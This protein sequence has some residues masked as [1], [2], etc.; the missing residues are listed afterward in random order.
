MLPKNSTQIFRQSL[1]AGTFALISIGMA[2]SVLAQIL[3]MPSNSAANPELEAVKL[4]METL[5]SRSDVRNIKLKKD[6]DKQITAVCYEQKNTV[7]RTYHDTANHPR[8]YADG[9]GEGQMN[10][11]K[12]D[13]YAARSGGGEF[14]RGFDDGYFGRANTG[15]NASATVND[16]S[17]DESKWSDE[18]ASV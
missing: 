14:S 15:Q 18:C 5:R 2:N 9:Y 11:R 10:A 3:V 7:T 16:Y 17:R 6:T 1:L 8:A 4:I 12:G 13:K